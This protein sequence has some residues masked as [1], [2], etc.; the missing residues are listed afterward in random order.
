MASLKEFLKQLS[1]LSA[2][3]G[4][5][6][7]V[8]SF[9]EREFKKLGWETKRD[10]LGNVIARKG[11]GRK[12]VLVA[13]HMDE[14]SMAVSAITKEGFIKFTKIG[15]IYD[16]I[17]GTARVMLHAR[18]K[19]PG[20]IGLKPPHLMKE[21]EAKKLVEIEALY[22]DIGA[23]NKEEVEK[24]G[25]RPGTPI[26]FL[27]NFRELA[28]ECVCGKAF[29]DR[30]GCAVLLKLAEELR[31]PKELTVFLVGTV[32]EETGLWGAG[33]SAFAIEP[34]LAVAVDVCFGGGTPDVPEDVVP[35]KLGSGPAIGVIESGGRGLIMSKKLVEWI[36]G[37][38]KKNK[39]ACQFEV[40]ERG[41]TDASRMQYIKTGFLAASI[42]V[43]TRYI[44]SENEVLSLKDL[45]AAKNLVKAVVQEFPAYK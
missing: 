7:E 34:D 41:A 15:G 16:G 45:E 38:A 29:D 19:I 20:V 28:N 26:T 32:R 35:V 42:G 10:V 1:E 13:A 2:P 4:D 33:T 44:H 8:A 17:L 25:I 9:M 12:K 27:S 37:I 40:H 18:E 5:E 43:P 21:E 24:K 30:V 3:T 6:E 23:K 11:S 39:I 14:I 36:E 22:I 31:V